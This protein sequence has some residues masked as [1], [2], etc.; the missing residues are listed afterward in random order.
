M[1]RSECSVGQYVKTAIRFD[2]PVNLP[3]GT[4]GQVIE[5]L[6]EEARIQFPGRRVKAFYSAFEKA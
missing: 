6:P 2:A 1:D 5:C 3:P 4:L